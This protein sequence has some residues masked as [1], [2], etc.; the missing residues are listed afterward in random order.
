MVSKRRAEGFE[1][2]TFLF[3]EDL[4]LRSNVGRVHDFLVG[5]TRVLGFL[6]LMLVLI[7]LWLVQGLMQQQ[8][9]MDQANT[10]VLCQ[11][12]HVFD[13]IYLRNKLA[14]M[15]SSTL[16]NDIYYATVCPRH[17]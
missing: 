16:L 5:M 4:S 11:L 6:N 13:L 3:V 17:Q 7:D 8:R 15:C 10:L 14:L 1:A 9:S 12:H 2:E